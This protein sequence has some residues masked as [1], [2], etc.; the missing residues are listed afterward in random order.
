M[1]SK[2]VRLIRRKDK[3]SLRQARLVVAGHMLFCGWYSYR[4]RELF[5]AIGDLIVFEILRKKIVCILYTEILVKE[6]D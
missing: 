3:A 4:Y 6:S 1:T 5:E 2:Q